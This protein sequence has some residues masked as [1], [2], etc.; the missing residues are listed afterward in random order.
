M[1]KRR[2]QPNLLVLFIS[3]IFI[4][5]SGAF[6]DSE[7]NFISDFDSDNNGVVSQ[8]EYTGPDKN[9]INLDSDNDGYVDADESPEGPPPNRQDRPD[10]DSDGD[11]LISEDEFHGTADHFDELDTDD[12]GYIDEGETPDAPPEGHDR[13]DRHGHGPGHRG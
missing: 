10:M 3:L 2:L 8:D 5:S 7:R 9:F 13:G 1:R 4:F 6:A 11:G 12:S